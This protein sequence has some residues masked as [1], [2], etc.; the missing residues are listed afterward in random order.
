MASN[1]P[2]R[3]TSSDCHGADLNHVGLDS[4]E[5]FQH[6]EHVGQPHPFSQYLDELQGHAQGFDR[7]E[8]G[9]SVFESS[10]LL[11]V[12]G[13]LCGLF[14]KWQAWV[15]QSRAATLMD[16]VVEVK[17]A[18]YAFHDRFEELPG[19]TAPNG[20]RNGRVDTT[21]ESANLWSHLFQAGYLT[22]V[23]AAFP[24][25]RCAN[26]FCLPNGFG[27][28]MQVRWDGESHHLH[29]GDGIP[30]RTLSVLDERYDDGLPRSGRIQISN[31]LHCEVEGYY[32]E[33]SSNC[34]AKYIWL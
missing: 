32:R 6:S 4:S 16:Q 27:G 31:T 10:M 9:I 7:P 5:S 14:F 13:I 19:D 29:I 17:A 20:N 23:E 26:G 18:W 30:A 3:V 34:D 22:Q 24:D 33:G 12:I 8:L 15:D 2:G 21:V 11:L 28:H 25:V 1:I